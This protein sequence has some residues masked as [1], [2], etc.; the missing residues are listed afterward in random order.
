MPFDRLFSG[1]EVM[2][3]QVRSSRKDNAVS[4]GALASEA[5]RRF[6]AKTQ[7]S[8]RRK[9]AKKKNKKSLANF[10]PALSRG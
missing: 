7:R 10:E 6:H 5:R 8:Q 9:D 2:L 4:F 3:P 1:F